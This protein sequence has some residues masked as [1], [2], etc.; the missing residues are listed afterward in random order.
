MEN[1]KIF[2]ILGNRMS[3]EWFMSALDKSFSGPSD[4][5]LESNVSGK[6]RIDCTDIKK[7]G[8]EKQFR[9]L[10]SQGLFWEISGQMA[11]S[12]EED[13]LATAIKINHRGYVFTFRIVSYELGEDVCCENVEDLIIEIAEN[14]VAEQP[15]SRTV[16]LKVMA[17]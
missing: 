16:E 10:V 14:T 12:I 3:S 9:R 7:K 15:I 6:Y 2:Y 13:T 5:I 1:L 8:K 17:A 11:E 4:L